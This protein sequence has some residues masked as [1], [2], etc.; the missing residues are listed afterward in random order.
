MTYGQEGIPYFLPRSV[1]PGPPAV[2]AGCG[3]VLLLTSWAA[4][5]TPFSQA[6]FSAH[7]E[8]L[9]KAGT[10]VAEQRKMMDRAGD[11]ECVGRRQRPLLHGALDTC[12]WSDFLQE[13]LGFQ[14]PTLLLLTRRRRL[15]RACPRCR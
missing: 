15:V 13:I 14:T 3:L 12:F 8:V 4:S 10:Y 1:V 11:N 5:A 9:L 6:S 7:S 2:P